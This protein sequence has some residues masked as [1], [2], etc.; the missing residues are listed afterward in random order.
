MARASASE[1]FVRRFFDSKGI[2]IDEHPVITGLI[3][4]GDDNR[5]IG[6][7]SSDAIPFYGE[8]TFEHPIRKGIKY[9]VKGTTFLFDVDDRPV[10]AT[11]TTPDEALKQLDLTVVDCYRFLNMLQR[12]E[13]LNMVEF[14]PECVIYF[15]DKEA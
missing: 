9:T 4:E 14:D 11:P 5:V 7:T 13:G 6:F 2:D 3:L 1:L 10:P 12:A 8:S 15:C